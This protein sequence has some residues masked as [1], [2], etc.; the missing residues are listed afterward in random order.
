MYKL[1]LLASNEQLLWRSVWTRLPYG[2][3]IIAF[4][5]KALY[6]RLEKRKYFEMRIFRFHEMKTF[7]YKYI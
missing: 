7:I 2:R 1:V 4:D 6:C 3:S 5:S